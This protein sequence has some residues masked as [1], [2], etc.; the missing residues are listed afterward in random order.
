MTLPPTSLIVCSRNR[1]D[2][3]LEAIRSILAGEE[4][5]AEIIIVDQS[6]APDERLK[7]L[8]TDRPCA[9]RYLWTQ[10]IG[11]SRA[12]NHGIACAQYDRIAFTH[13]DVTVTPGWFGALTRALLNAGEHTVVTGRVLPSESQA[14]GGFVLTIK[15]DAAPTIYR[16]RV[17]QDVLL[18]LNMALHRSAVADVGGFDVR[19]GPGETFPAAEDNDLGFRLLEAGYCIQYVPEAVLYHRAWRGAQDYLPLRWNY[20]YA[21]GAFYA[22]HFRGNDGY[23]RGR[24]WEDFSRHASR[25]FRY[26]LRRSRRQIY[27]DVIYSFGLVYGATKWWLTQRKT[28]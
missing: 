27:S 4:V 5:P 1:P 11:L 25:L 7:S 12:N 24:M 22:K 20:A 28:R 21:Q 10:T 9:I 15:T 13:D 3:L 8:Q 6:D 17:S 23:I 18:P 19:L 2:M 26:G 16:G 14:S